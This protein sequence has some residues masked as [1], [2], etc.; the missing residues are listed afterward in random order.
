[1]SVK[2]HAPTL[3]VGSGNQSNP[4]SVGHGGREVKHHGSTLCF[5]RFP[6]L[7]LNDYFTVVL[8]ALLN[9]F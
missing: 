9:T 6:S 3:F 2:Y 5:Q 1:M 8:I 4:L 7:K